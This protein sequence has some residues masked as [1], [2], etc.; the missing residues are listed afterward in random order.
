MNPVYE[1]CVR[2][3]FGLESVTA[4]ELRHLGHAELA[5]ENGRILFSGG[6]GDLARCNYRLRT[7]DRVQLRLAAFTADNLDALFEGIRTVPW[8]DILPKEAA[9]TAL[10]RCDKGWMQSERTC[11][12]LTKKAVI[13]VMQRK[14]GVETLPESGR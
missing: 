6:A 4:G 7:A 13:T 1:I 12:S 5:T 9:V 2:T 11:Q 8:G 3:A 14:Y 10:A